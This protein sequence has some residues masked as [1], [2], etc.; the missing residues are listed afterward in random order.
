MATIAQQPGGTPQASPSVAD[1]LAAAHEAEAQAEAD[2]IARNSR[3]P[4]LYTPGFGI[5]IV[6]T[7]GV[8]TLVGVVHLIARLWRVAA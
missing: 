4:W 3:T 2:V 6:L 7:V 8:L 5:A 1:A